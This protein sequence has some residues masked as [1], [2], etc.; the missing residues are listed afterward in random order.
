VRGGEK[1]LKMYVKL[2]TRA[3]PDVKVT[4]REINGVPA[5]LSEDPA[6]KRPNGPRVVI[7]LDLDRDGKIRTLYSVTAPDKLGK[8]RWGF[9]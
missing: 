2:A 4:V 6:P 7:L 3:S 9:G 1:V 5:I 8:I